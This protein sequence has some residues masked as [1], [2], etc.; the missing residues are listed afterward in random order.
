[1]ADINI[2]CHK[3]QTETTISEFVDD[4]NLKCRSC[5][6][7]LEKPGGLIQAAT[8]DSSTKDTTTIK[9]K[10]K[11]RVARRKKEPTI[12]EEEGQASLKYIVNQSKNDNENNDKKVTLRPKVKAKKSLINH[13]IIAGLLFLVLGGTLGYLRYGEVLPDKYLNMSAQYA[14]IVFLAFHG[15]ITIKALSD[16]MLQG[17][18]CL[19]VPGYSLF[20]IF[21]ISDNFYLRAIFAG[22]LI[23]IAEDAA[24]EIKARATI[25]ADGASKFISSG[26]GDVR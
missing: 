16:N 13:T 17:I 15:M 18:L 3:C 9:V 7:T 2:T 20:Y 8:K 11:L 24:T 19:L 21:A 12:T 14:W 25:I 10:S 26:G 6:V 1:M 22:L 4:T 23:G 5:G